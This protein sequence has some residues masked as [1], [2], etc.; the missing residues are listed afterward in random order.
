V[1]RIGVKNDVIARRQEA[2]Y[3]ELFQYLLSIH[4]DPGVVSGRIIRIMSFI[5]EIKVTLSLL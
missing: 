1:T 3:A 2:L 4:H 5:H